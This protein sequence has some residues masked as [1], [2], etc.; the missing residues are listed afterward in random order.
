M[1]TTT[2]T[3]SESCDVKIDKTMATIE[4]ESCDGGARGEVSR[5]KGLGFKVLEKKVCRK[6]GQVGG[7]GVDRQRWVGKFKGEGVWQVVEGWWVGWTVDHCGQGGWGFFFKCQTTPWDKDL[8]VRFHPIQKIP[9]WD[10][11]DGALVGV[12]SLGP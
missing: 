8:K 6:N 4:R 1:T 3:T 11:L 2:T 12:V 9:E 7:K 5:R 10:F